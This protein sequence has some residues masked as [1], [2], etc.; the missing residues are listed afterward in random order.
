MKIE[1]A[2]TDL[3]D[4]RG[5]L[6]QYAAAHPAAP[7]EYKEAAVKLVKRLNMALK[8]VHGHDCNGQ[9]YINVFE[10]VRSL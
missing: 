2:K 8:E 3:Y 6:Y 1:I 5:I 4:I 10:N 9:S 7:K